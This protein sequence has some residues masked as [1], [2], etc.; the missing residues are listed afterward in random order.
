MLRTLGFSSDIKFKIL[1]VLV[2]CENFSKKS[3]SQPLVLLRPSQACLI[4]DPLTLLV[5]SS[6][7][8]YTFSPKPTSDRTNI[9]PLT[10]AKKKKRNTAFA[11]FQMLQFVTI[12][13]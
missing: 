4:D 13:L 10:S 2:H 8:V 9:F 12:L 7:D 11:C 3:S 6:N 1:L 5:S